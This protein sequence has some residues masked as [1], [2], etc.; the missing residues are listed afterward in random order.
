MKNNIDISQAKVVTFSDPSKLLKHIDSDR[1]FY[2]A[3]D[4]Y[5]WETPAS[6]IYK[7]ME[8]LIDETISDIYKQVKAYREG[9][10]LT[11]IFHLKDKLT[12]S[13]LTQKRA[14]LAAEFEG[15]LTFFKESLKGLPPEDLPDKI[16]ELERLIHTY[17]KKNDELSAAAHKNS[18][19]G[20]LASTIIGLKES[21]TELKAQSE[22]TTESKNY[23][24]MKK[25]K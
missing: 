16:A 11:P 8:K 22:G 18:S 12:G 21:I 25:I 1:I 14:D 6:Q 23:T 5:M 3:H 19:S 10:L 7:N 20:R 13:T 17:Q 2:P 4:K 9:E 15:E 24:S